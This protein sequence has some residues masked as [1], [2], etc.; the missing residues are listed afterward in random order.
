MG[1]DLQVERP[2]LPTDPGIG[3]Y[4][5]RVGSAATAVAEAS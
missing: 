3:V 5:V 1:N 4:A 2:L